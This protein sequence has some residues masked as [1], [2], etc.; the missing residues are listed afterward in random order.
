MTLSAALQLPAKMQ[1]VMDATQKFVVIIGGRGSAKSES[2]ARILLTKASIEKCDVL[3]CREYQNSLSDSV[4]KL[5]C[6]VAK[7]SGMDWVV[8]TEKK[9]RLRTGGEFTFKGLATHSS[10]IRSAQNMKYLW[11]EEAQG[12]SKQSIQDTLPTIRAP[13]SQLF[14][15]ANPMSSADAFSKRF[16]NRWKKELDRDGFYEDSEH[17]II[18]MNWQ[19]NPFHEELEPMRVWDKKYLPRAE[20]DHIWEG[21]FNDSVD[22]SI[23]RAEWFD[24]AIDFHIE[25]GFEPRGMKVVSHD[26]ADEGGDA[27]GL[28]YRHGAVILEVLEKTDGDVNDACDWA[29]GLANSIQ[30][31]VFNWDADGLGAALKAQIGTAFEGKKVNV[32]MFKGSNSP[33]NPNEVY[34]PDEII[35]RREAKTNKE[36]F[37]NKR[38]QYYIRLR[39]RFF[40]SYLWREKGQ[41]QIP[42][43]C[44][45][46]SSKI[47]CM[48]QL[49]SEVC[50]IP[51]KPNASGFIQIQNK[52]EMLTK[53][54]IQSPNL[55]DSLMMSMVIPDPIKPPPAPL[56]I[57]DRIGLNFD[58]RHRRY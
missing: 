2:M 47:N 48:T 58:I 28:V 7:D 42:E 38:A 56:T 14:F 21:A 24:A 37:R 44:I 33:D 4:H 3:C 54:N 13:G 16:I 50:R 29:T 17:L 10:A 6:D 15:T 49:R 40:K 51:K 53:H 36:T 39:D 5:L 52:Q 34:Q 55:A 32:K 45:S 30:A 22:G 23:I 19:S 27:K 35:E 41:H 1:W 26:P 46:I 25:K 31:D 8:P 12:L 11:V 57:P 9:I 20:Y 43:D 18:V